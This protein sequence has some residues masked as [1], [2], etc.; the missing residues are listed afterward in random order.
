LEDIAGVWMHEEDGCIV[1][2]PV[3]VEVDDEGGPTLAWLKAKLDGAWIEAVYVAPDITVWCDEEFR[4]KSLKPT[5]LVG[6]PRGLWDFGGPIVL[7]GP[8]EK[9]DDFMTTS[10][11]LPPEGFQLAPP[12]IRFDRF[13]PEEN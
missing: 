4:L 10:V 9:L 11:R 3:A 13:D 6:G 8:K 2:E 7:T 1:T 12:F 5:A